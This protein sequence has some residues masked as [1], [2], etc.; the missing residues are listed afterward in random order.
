MAYLGGRLDEVALD[1]YAQAD[2]GSVWYLGEDVFDYAHGTVSAT[3]GT[4]LAGRDGPAAMIM[5]AKPKVGDVFRTE[6]ADGIVFEEVTVKTVGKTVAGP[7]GP[8][9]GAMVGQELHSDG[10]HEDKV[11]APAYGE[12]RTAGGGDLEAMALAVPA[13]ALKGPPPPELHALSTGSGAVLESARIGDWP[14]AT[15]TL[16]HLD[17]AWSAVRAG[18]PPPMV[19]ARLGGS[20]AALSSGSATASPPRSPLPRAPSSTRGL[21]GLRSAADARNLPAAGDHP[22]RLGARMRNLAA[23]APSG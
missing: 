4:W 14:A 15:A 13:D 11:F 1:R 9:R 16:G 23:S 5:P 19:A 2:D 21:R 18:R 3:E 6:N 22:A 17:S 10:T 8:V 7:H 12:F 20:L